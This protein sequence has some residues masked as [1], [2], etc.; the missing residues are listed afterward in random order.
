M[1][2]AMLIND[3]EPG[4]A[5]LSP[6]EMETRMRDIFGWFEKW[7]AEGKISDFGAQL[8]K[9]HTARTVRAGADGAPVVTDGPYLELKEV[10]GGFVVLE[11]ADQDEAV[12]IASTWPYLDVSSIEIRPVVVHG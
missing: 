1:K 9:S 4:W 11:T 6:A 5:A 10:I 12:S 7:G 2:F 8:E 3:D